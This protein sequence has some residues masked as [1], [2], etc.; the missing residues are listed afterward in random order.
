MLPESHNCDSFALHTS[1]CSTISQPIS[2]DFRSPEVAV[3][4]GNMAAL[5]ATMPKA[6]I[7]IE[8]HF[9]HWKEK[10][11]PSCDVPRVYDPAT[12]TP[13]HKGSSK[14]PLGALVSKS[15]YGSHD[16]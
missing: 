14:S 16:L 2:D 1:G 3:V 11:G 5:R 10:I 9:F 8:S 7:Y 13:A 4:F 12:N 15:F 6:P